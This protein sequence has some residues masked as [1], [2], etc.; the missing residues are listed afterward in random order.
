[1]PIVQKFQYKFSDGTILEDPM[2]IFMLRKKWLES[3]PVANQQEYE[4]ADI[5]QKKLRDQIIDS[6]K[7]VVDENTNF[8]W[9]TTDDKLKGKPTDPVWQKYFDQFLSDNKMEFLIV[10]EEI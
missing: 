2:E 6:G 3:L 7:L 8:V 9:K 1:M 4:L 5:R 10:E